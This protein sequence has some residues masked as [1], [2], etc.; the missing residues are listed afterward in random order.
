[1]GNINIFY[2]KLIIIIK[3]WSEWACT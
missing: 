1:M 3:V 2:V